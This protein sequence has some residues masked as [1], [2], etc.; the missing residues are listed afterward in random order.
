MSEYFMLCDERKSINELSESHTIT[1]LKLDG[2]RAIWLNGHFVNRRGTDLTK[3]YAHIKPEAK[4]AVLDGE[5]VVFAE[6]WRTDFN[7]VRTTKHY[8]EAK[9]VVFDVLVWNGQRVT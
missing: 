7:K 9:Y 4:N 1:E 5:I 3:K 6:A 8:A 2:E